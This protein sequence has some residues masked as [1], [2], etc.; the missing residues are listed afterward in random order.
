MLYTYYD[1]NDKEYEFN[2]GMSDMGKKVRKFVLVDNGNVEKVKEEFKNDEDFVYLMDK[3]GNKN[4]VVVLPAD[5][6]DY[7]ILLCRLIEGGCGFM[8]KES[9]GSRGYQGKF[10]E[11]VRKPGSEVTGPAMVSENKMKGLNK[12]QRTQVISKNPK[13]RKPDGSL[14]K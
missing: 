4:D 8:F 10:P 6:T 13:I 5:K 12:E 9:T 11:L 3:V 14:W 7:G 1:E 2:I